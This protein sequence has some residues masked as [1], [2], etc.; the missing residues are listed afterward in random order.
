MLRLTASAPL[1]EPS[2]VTHDGGGSTQRNATVRDSEV[3][4]VPRTD[5]V[6]R[7]EARARRLQGWRDEL[8]IERLRV[9]R[10][11]APSGHYGYHYDWSRSGAATGGWGR[12]SSLMV[13]VD[14]GQLDGEGGGA[15]GSEPEPLKGG[16]TAFPRLARRSTDARWCRFIECGEAD[17][18]AD[19]SADTAD[20]DAPSGH[21]NSL[22]KG[23]VFK[24][25]PGNAVFWE[26][27]RP[28][29]TGQAYEESWHAGLRVEQGVKIG[30][31][32]WSW[33]R[34]D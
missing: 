11:Q 25:V 10:Y 15:G 7:I 27:F 9:Q 2:T 29:G 21:G 5:V 24:P 4:V 32:I 19:T 34:V 6:R 3:A 28:D 23:V 30:L 12:V 26:N 13:F 16:G 14:D 20:S 22:A 18:D 31:N 8:W 1:Y 17:A 33:G